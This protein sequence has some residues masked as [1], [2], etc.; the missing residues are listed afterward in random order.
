MIKRRVPKDN[1]TNDNDACFVNMKEVK[2]AGPY[3]ACQV[4]GNA[5]IL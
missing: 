2:I 1:Y 5:L 3:G 4:F